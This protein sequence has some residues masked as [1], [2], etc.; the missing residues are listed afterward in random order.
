M[1]EAAIAIPEEEPGPGIRHNECH[2]PPCPPL[3]NAARV[4][5]GPTGGESLHQLTLRL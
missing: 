3:G 2:R 4:V 1:V 5:K